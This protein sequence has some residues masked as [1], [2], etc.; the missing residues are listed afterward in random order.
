MVAN[1]AWHFL[2]HRVNNKFEYGCAAIGSVDW[3][4][5]RRKLRACTAV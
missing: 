1:Q 3:K 4:S 5:T 2:I